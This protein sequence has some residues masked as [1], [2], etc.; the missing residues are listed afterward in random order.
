MNISVKRL[1]ANIAKMAGLHREEWP[2]RVLMVKDGVSHQQGRT[3]TR[4]GRRDL[5]EPCSQCQLLYVNR[6][7]SHLS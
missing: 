4:E 3:G 1:K 2:A 7:L 5:E 6:H